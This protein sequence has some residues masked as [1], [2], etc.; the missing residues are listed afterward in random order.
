MDLTFWQVFF[1]KIIL[2]SAVAF[3]LAWF[4]P[5]KASAYGRGML[6]SMAVVFLPSCV[7]M[8]Q[9]DPVASNRAA[10]DFFWT[11]FLL[12][13]AWVVGAVTAISIARLIKWKDERPPFF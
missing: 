12:F 8:F 5:E 11:L 7:P 13:G 3:G 2:G 10:E 4:T 1:L 9:P 6:G